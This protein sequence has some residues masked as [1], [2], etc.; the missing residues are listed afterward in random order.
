MTETPIWKMRDW[1]LASLTISTGKPAAT[2]A[3]WTVNSPQEITI[4]EVRVQC[5]SLTLSRPERATG[6]G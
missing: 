4:Q 3:P 6:G 5:A 1:P 2:S